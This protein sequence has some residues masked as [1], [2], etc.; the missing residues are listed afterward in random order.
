MRMLDRLRKNPVSLHVSFFCD[1]VIGDT[2]LV[3]AREPRTAEDVISVKEALQ[4]RYQM[5]QRPVLI[6]WR[7]IGE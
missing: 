5:K 1:G 2:I 4:E 7:K 3:V 6:G